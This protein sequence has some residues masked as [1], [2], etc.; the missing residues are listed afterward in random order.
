MTFDFDKKQI[1]SKKDKSSIQGIDPGIKKLVNLINSHKDYYTTS[2]CA[3]RIQLILQGKKKCDSEWL[4]K[5]H[6]MVLLKDV[7]KALKQYAQGEL[8]FRQEAMILHVC[9]R[10]VEAA[11]LIL[12]FARQQGFKRSGIMAM[13]RRTIVEILSQEKVDTIIGLD[14]KI[15]VDD[16]YLELLIRIAN[17]KL[18]S[19][20]KKIKNLEKSL[21]SF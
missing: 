19:N 17:S 4:L 2:S 21:I 18:K 16:N 15:V 12:N 6:K 11:N 14:G 1:L 3:G 13:N 5:S 8:W 9:C 7:K 20:I 10:T